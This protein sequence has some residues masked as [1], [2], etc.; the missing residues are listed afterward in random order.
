[1]GEDDEGWGDEYDGEDEQVDADDT[2]WKVRKSAVKVIDAVIISCPAYLRDFWIS[3][4]Q[5]LQSRFIERDDNVKCDILQTFQN[6]IKVSVVVNSDSLSS[7]SSTGGISRTNSQGPNLQMEKRKSYL[8]DVEN[9]Y[10]TIVKTL[11][12]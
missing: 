2:A 10:G 5:L 4:V 8:A 3:Y 9:H 12:K 7:Q 6:L 1:M 11:L